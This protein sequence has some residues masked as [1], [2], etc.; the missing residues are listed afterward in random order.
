[1]P[2][3]EEYLEKNSKQLQYEDFEVIRVIG[4]GNFSKIFMVQHNKFPDKYFALKVV[5]I[6]KVASLRR[7]TD[8][9]LEKHSLNKIREAY[10]D[11]K[12]LPSV[13][14][15]ATFKD[16]GS[17]YFLTEMLQSKHELWNYVRNFGVLS[18]EQ[19]KYIFH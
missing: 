17:L 4:E 10:S 13:K 12:A 3:V 1:M 7:E 11:R 8:I 19:A 9:L 16:A 18:R 15:I 2:K 14:L 6:Q 5:N